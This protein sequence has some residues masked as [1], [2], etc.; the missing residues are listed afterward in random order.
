MHPLPTH[1]PYTFLGMDH[2]RDSQKPLWQLDTGTLK[3]R[4]GKCVVTV[5]ALM[6]IP[7]TYPFVF[8]FSGHP[9]TATERTNGNNRPF[10]ADITYNPL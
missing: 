7:S 4:S 10:L 1:P 3:D 2:Q 8:S 6:A 9:F 5:A